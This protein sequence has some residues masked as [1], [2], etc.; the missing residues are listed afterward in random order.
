MGLCRTSTDRW[1]RREEGGGRREKG[2][3]EEEEEDRRA[4]DGDRE[5]GNRGS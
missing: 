3:E 2:E 1:G 4:G 5:G